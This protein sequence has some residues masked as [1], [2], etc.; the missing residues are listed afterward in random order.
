MPFIQ[1]LSKK[2]V[3]REYETFEK[4]EKLVKEKLNE[5]IEDECI[6]KLDNR[7]TT[8]S[9]PA[10]IAIA[11]LD[12]CRYAIYAPEY[13]NQE[14]ISIFEHLMKDFNSDLYY[15]LKNLIFIVFS[16]RDFDQVEGY[17]I[18]VKLIE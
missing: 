6:Y 4:L 18:E 7:Y 10:I 13:L 8:D 17:G 5:N 9:G 16:K 15:H 14:Q 3:Q 1:T 12:D 11:E 2:V